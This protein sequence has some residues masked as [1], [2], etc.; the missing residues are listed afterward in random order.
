LYEVVQQKIQTIQKLMDRHT[1]NDLCYLIIFKVLPI[2]EN[3]WPMYVAAL[4]LHLALN[5]CLI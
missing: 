3:K 4:W 5:P 1:L 2:L